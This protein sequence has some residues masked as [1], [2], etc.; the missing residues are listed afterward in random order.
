[1]T[2]LEAIANENKAI[3][4]ETALKDDCMRLS[5]TRLSQMKNNGCHEK[6][7]QGELASDS[8]GTNKK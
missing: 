1:M 7:H 2:Q 4:T 8:G 6:K 5:I 3:Q